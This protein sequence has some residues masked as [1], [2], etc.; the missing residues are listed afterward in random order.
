LEG[1]E[2]VDLLLEGGVVSF[3]IFSLKVVDD[4]TSVNGGGEA[5][6]D[7]SDKV[8]DTLGVTICNHTF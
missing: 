6:R 8:G 1:G 4:V 5:V 2:C 3:E 7:G